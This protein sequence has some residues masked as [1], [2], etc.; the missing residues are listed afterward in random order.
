MLYVGSGEGRWSGLEAPDLSDNDST[1]IE[2][3]ASQ[4][5]ALSDEAITQLASEGGFATRSRYC[6]E[7]GDASTFYWSKRS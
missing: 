3:F 5:Q 2:D 7:S 6:A 4:Y 1:A